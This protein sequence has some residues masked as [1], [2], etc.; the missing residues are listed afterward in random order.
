LNTASLGEKAASELR[1]GMV[2]VG[3][4]YLIDVD[5]FMNEALDFENRRA[6][7]FGEFSSKCLQAARLL[8]GSLTAAVSP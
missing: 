4:N 2:V 3:I 1:S 7:Y 5:Y 6:A 8:D